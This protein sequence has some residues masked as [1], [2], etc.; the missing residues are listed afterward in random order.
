MSRCCAFCCYLVTILYCVVVKFNFKLSVKLSKFLLQCCITYVGE[1]STKLI[2]WN[3]NP[4][5]NIFILFIF[6]SSEF[7]IPCWRPTATL[8]DKWWCYFS[9]SIF[10]SSIRRITEII[11]SNI[12]LS[13]R[14]RRNVVRLAARRQTHR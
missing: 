6:P 8:F 12:R 1:Y 2:Q 4:N 13:R 5:C 10:N 14:H 3:S 7:R 11:I 9:N